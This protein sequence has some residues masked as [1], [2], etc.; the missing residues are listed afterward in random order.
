MRHRL[1]IVDVPQDDF[2]NPDHPSARDAGVPRP[3]FSHLRRLTNE[4]GLWEHA[5]QS[6]PR[7]EHGFCTDDNA[8]ALVIGAREQIED[9]TDLLA[10]YIRF[11]LAAR[12]PDGTFHNRRDAAGTW[13][14]EKGSDDSQGRAWWGFGA[15]ARQAPEEWMRAT[16][17]EQFDSC[18]TFQ[19]RHVRAN[20]YAALGAVELVT[21]RVA[22]QPAVELL[23]RTSTLITAAARSTI[24]WPEVR[25]TYDNAR[26]PE[27]L[28]AAGVALGDERRTT[29]GIRLLE[30][31]T[32]NESRVDH[33]SFTPAGG[34]RPGDPGPGFDQQ[35]LEAWAMADACY[36]AWTVTGESV[37]RRRALQAGRWL[38]GK[39][40]KAAVLYDIKT[41][42]TFDGL[43]PMGVNTN[44]GAEST[45]AG[46]GALQVAAK[47]RPQ[48]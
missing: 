1:W 30:W 41:G 46:I 43:T 44:Q 6:T 5:L 20:A 24:P 39:N 14:D 42:S 10:T 4:F 13:V 16:A 38:L 28:I 18:A 17:L 23:D 45:L 36:R 25:L 29:L 47:C 37:W 32:G 8:R 12:K 34:R 2:T 3:I 48:P 40:D 7:K 27:A 19:S 35:P 11:V 9:V 33:F 31:L 26:I 21:E 15:I 22:F